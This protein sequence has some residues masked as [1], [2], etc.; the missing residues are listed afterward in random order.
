[1]KNGFKELGI[2]EELFKNND[3]DELIKKYNDE[4]TN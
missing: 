3:K 2:N 4:T 1:M